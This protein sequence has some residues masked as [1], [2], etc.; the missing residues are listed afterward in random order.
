MILLWILKKK[1]D[2]VDE[3]DEKTT[4]TELVKQKNNN[5]DAE[6]DLDIEKKLEKPELTLKNDNESSNTLEKNVVN[7]LNEINLEYSDIEDTMALKSPRAVYIEL[8][9]EAKRRAKES[10]KA[11]ILAVLEL[12]RIKNKYML[13][14]MESSDDEFELEETY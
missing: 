2:E 6:T 7:G 10:K 8:Y 13:D 3:V 4:T 1:V 11:A 12:K 9:N 14:E 5:L